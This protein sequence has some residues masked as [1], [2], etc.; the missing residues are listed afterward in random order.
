MMGL[1]L[2][3]NLGRYHKARQFSRDASHHASEIRQISAS[4]VAS[5]CMKYLMDVT[6]AL[7]GLLVLSPMIIMLMGS[8]LILQGRPIFIAHRRI[9]KNGVMF[10][11]LKF[12]TMVRNADEVLS[13]HLNANPS[14][15]EE[16]NA[17]R[18]LRDDPRITPFGALL[19]KSSIDELPQLINIIRGEMS[20][21]GPRPIVAGE[22]EL[23]GIH[24]SDYIRVRPG[25]TGLWQVSGRSDMSYS[26][27]VQL[28][29]RYVAEQSLVGDIAIMLKT[30]PAVLLSR[31]SY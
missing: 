25:L 29:A 18:K 8:L 12:R 17:T 31:G 28:D 13:R 30:I 26:E 1:D 2:D 3:R 19:R 7:I 10:P 27:R 5:T 9:G 21:V 11:C 15:R 4:I 16:W 22:A 24:Y 23:Y 20:L 6:I 14:L